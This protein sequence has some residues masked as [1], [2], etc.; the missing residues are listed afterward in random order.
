MAAQ[1]FDS[2]I[3]YRPAIDLDAATADIVEAIKQAEERG[4]TAATLANDSDRSAW[5]DVKADVLERG[6]SVVVC[7]RDVI[8]GDS[9]AN[10]SDI[11]GIWLIN[12]SR[13]LVEL[14]DEPC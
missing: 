2:N 5:L 9:T 8:E 12:H 3:I 14:S 4:F 1:A 10:F 13:L 11:L 6:L 7:E